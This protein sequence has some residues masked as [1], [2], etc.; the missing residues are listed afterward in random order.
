M[1]GA[2]VDGTPLVSLWFTF[3]WRLAG[4]APV[5]F[6]VVDVLELSG[7]G[8]IAALRIIYDTSGARPVFE[9]Q[10]AGVPGTPACRLTPEPATELVRLAA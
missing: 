9:A 4:G 1:D 2:A 10:R 7:D 8:Q 6:D 3:G 5:S